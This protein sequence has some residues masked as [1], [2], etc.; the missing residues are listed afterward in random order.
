M[1][2]REAGS[3]AFTVRAARPEDAAAIMSVHQASVRGL[4]AAFYSDEQIDAWVGHKTPDDYVRSV[5]AGERMWV[6]WH[7]PQALGFAAQKGD[8]IRAVYVHPDGGGRGIGRRLLRAAEKAAWDDGLR[9][10]HLDASLNAVPFYER[11]GY[12]GGPIAPHRLQNGTLIPSM[13]MSKDLGSDRSIE[14]KT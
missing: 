6:A 4:C 13:P 1:S 11:M 12:R 10:V 5:G 14:R 8:E 7:G 2:M 9:S 3:D